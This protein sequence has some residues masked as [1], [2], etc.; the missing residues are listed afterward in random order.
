MKTK[1]IFIFGLTACSLILSSCATPKFKIHNLAEFPSERIVSTKIAVKTEADKDI[2]RSLVERFNQDAREEN[3]GIVISPTFIFF[4]MEVQKEKWKKCRETLPCFADFVFIYHQ[5]YDV[6]IFFDNDGIVGDIGRLIIGGEVAYID[7]QKVR[8]I[9]LHTAS[10]DKFK[11]EFYHVFH[12]GHSAFGVMRQLRNLVGI[13]L[14]TSS[15]LSDAS[16][17]EIEKNKWRIFE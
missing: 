15:Q 13:P 8:Y 17:A 7:N 11:H 16:K 5:P 6:A 9:I 12:P 4:S 3:T 10:Y 14:L 2:M 1:T